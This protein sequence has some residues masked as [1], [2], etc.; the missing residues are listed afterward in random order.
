MNTMPDTTLPTLDVPDTAVV[1][2]FPFTPSREPGSYIASNPGTIHTPLEFFKLF[3]SDSIVESTCTN[4]NKYAEK[5]KDSKPFMFSKYP[6]VDPLPAFE[7]YGPY[8]LLRADE[9]SIVQGLPDSKGAL[10][11]CCMVHLPSTLTSF[12]VPC[13]SFTFWILTV[14]TKLI[15]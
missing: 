7:T 15:I 11:M 8:H 10:L 5:K 6:H 1:M 9:A 3:F 2:S 13:H 4:S 14:R 12:R